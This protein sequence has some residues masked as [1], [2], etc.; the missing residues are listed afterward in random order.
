M[1]PGA[2]SLDDVDLDQVSV[3]YVLNCAKKG[4]ML[5]LSEAIRDYHDATLFPSVV[6][7]GSTDEF[8][9]VTD[10]TTSGSPPR[11]APPSVPVVVPTPILSSLSIS[12]PLEGEQLEESPSL[13]K[14][15]SLNSSQVK[16]LTVDDIDDFDD[17]VLEEVES[18][19]Y[20]RRV[21]NDASDVVLGL[22]SFATGIT[23]DDLR[24]TAY[25]ILLA[26]AGASGGLIVPS[27]D[28]KKEKKSRLMKKLGRSKSE[29][30]VTQSQNS[31]GLVGLLETM[32]VQMEDGLIR[33][34]LDGGPS[35]MFTPADAKLLEEDLEVLK[36]FFISGGDGLPR[37]VV[38]NQVAR[39]RQVIKLHGYET[40]ELIEDLKS[41]SEMEM[42]GGRSKLG[43]DAKTLIRILCHRSDSEASQFLKKQAIDRLIV[44]VQL[45]DYSLRCEERLLLFYTCKI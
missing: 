45:I 33:V 31:H 40:R 4:G 24:E 17:D 1:P 43:A 7:S 28:K 39:L 13:S 16:E 32:R 27:K 38:E 30:V 35:R 20:S 18:R 3:D 41:A 9:L 37:G 12:E 23:D 10:P 36:E 6:R 44:F 11:R 42:Q 21:L 2:V 5:E 8:F 26:A 22:P 14:S 25:E 19:R 29:H 34:I 15:Q